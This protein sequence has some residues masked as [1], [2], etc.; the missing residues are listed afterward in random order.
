MNKT[1]LPASCQGAYPLLGE[2]VIKQIIILMTIEKIQYLLCAKHFMWIFKFISCN[3]PMTLILIIFLFLE[4]T[5]KLHGQDHTQL[6]SDRAR[7]QT[8]AVWL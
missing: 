2:V 1:G 3:S 8:Q 5:K 4:C 6:V 7:F